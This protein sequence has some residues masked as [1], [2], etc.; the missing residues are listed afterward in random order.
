VHDLFK[1][2]DLYG[3]NIVTT[4]AVFIDGI[5]INLKRYWNGV[6]R[7]GRGIMLLGHILD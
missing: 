6:R 2:P 4:L 3:N 1:W 5:S 7:G